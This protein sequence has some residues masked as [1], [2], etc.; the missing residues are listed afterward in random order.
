MLNR[1]YWLKKVLK[2]GKLL[3]KLILA[4]SSAIE[5]IPGNDESERTNNLSTLRLRLQILSAHGYSSV[6]LR[7]DDPCQNVDCTFHGVEK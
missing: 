6:L 3:E 2:D 7:F 5:N 1:H 4:G